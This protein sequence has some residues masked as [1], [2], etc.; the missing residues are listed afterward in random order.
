MLATGKVKYHD[1]FR[2]AFRNRTNG[3]Y[4]EN[5]TLDPANKAYGNTVVDEIFE[6]QEDARAYI[7]RSHAKQRHRLYAIYGHSTT[8]DKMHYLESYRWRNGKWNLLFRDVH[9]SPAKKYDV[10]FLNA[11]GKKI[12]CPWRIVNLDF[13]R[14][15]VRDNGDKSRTYVVEQHGKE[16]LKFEY[17]KVPEKRR[18]FVDGEVQYVEVLVDQWVDTK[19]S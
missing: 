9:K 6:T 4:E 8:N 11:E 7:F 13:L 19:L 18:E 17:K 5:P 14:R 2:I 10:Y 1:H 15:N 16:I 12:K 3:Q